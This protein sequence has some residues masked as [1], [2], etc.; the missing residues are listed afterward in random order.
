MRLICLPYAGGSAMVYARWRRGLPSWIEV[1]P[2]ELP[3]RGAR[4]D[5]PLQTDATALVDQLASELVGT[6]LAEP[7]V[8][9]GHSLGGLLAF[10]LAHRLLALGAP[11][12][13]M[14]LVSGTEAPAVRDGSRWREPLG[15]AALREELLRLNGTPPE[16]LQSMEIMRSTLPI[17]R[18]DFLMCGNYVY[19][20][21]QPLPCPLHVF[22]G[23]LD[24][25][26]AEALE[27][28]RAE[29]SGTFGRD[30][31]PGDHF[32]IHSQQADLLKLVAALLVRRAW[33]EPAVARAG[34]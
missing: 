13:Q 27:A 18:A 2:L 31:L 15:D 5:E 32:F 28:W 11:R 3:G 9:F 16:A 17:L 4:M 26:R 29:T 12:P 7:Y 1:Q 30:M 20:R 25:T 22:G 19:R 14:L 34:P 33:P 21:R 6:P 24:E 10:E 23:E 8:L